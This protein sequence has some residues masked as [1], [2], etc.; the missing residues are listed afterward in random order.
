M[1][2]PL[3][4]RGPLEQSKQ[5][6][7]GVTVVQLNAKQDAIFGCVNFGFLDSSPLSPFSDTLGLVSV[8]LQSHPLKPNNTHSPQ[9]GWGH[10][11]KHSHVQQRRL[12]LREVSLS[13][14]YSLCGRGKTH[15]QVCLIPRHS[16][17]PGDNE[18][19]CFGKFLGRSSI[20]PWLC[21]S[22]RHHHTEHLP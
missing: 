21:W 5:T 15:T 3:A 10:R 9:A 13:Q 2:W 17:A 22:D 14:D 4:P 16:H 7:Q 11:S 20:G 19:L 1:A 12:G 6:L 18:G 8:L